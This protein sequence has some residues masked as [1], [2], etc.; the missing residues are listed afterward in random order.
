MELRINRVR[1][2]R[3]RPVVEF[4]TPLQPIRVT[5]CHW[6]QKADFCSV[7]S[8]CPAFINN[9]IFKSPNGE[10]CHFYGIPANEYEDLM[11]VKTDLVHFDFQSP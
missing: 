4:F 5:V 11:K 2:N 6:R 8:G 10:D 1:I 9:G 7:K 3:A